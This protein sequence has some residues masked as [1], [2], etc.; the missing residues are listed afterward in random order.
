MLLGQTGEHAMLARSLGVSKL[1]VLVN[2]MDE[3]NWDE[4]RFNFIKE[5]FEPFLKGACGFD[6]KDIEW[7]PMSGTS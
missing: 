1:I 6:N 3:V 4:K 5:Q 7:I 2:K